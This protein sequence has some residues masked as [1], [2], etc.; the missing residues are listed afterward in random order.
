MDRLFDRRREND[1]ALSEEMELLRQKVSTLQEIIQRSEAELQEEKQKHLALQEKTALWKEKVKQSTMNDRRRIAELEEKLVLLKTVHV[2]ADAISE[3]GAQAAG[4]AVEQLSEGHIPSQQI[5]MHELQKAKETI[6]QR[7]AELRECQQSLNMLRD[8]HVEMQQRFSE[9]LEALTEHHRA[10][11]QK[12][13]EPSSDLERTAV[14]EQLVDEQK[15]KLQSLQDLTRQQNLQN[16]QLKGKIDDLQITNDALEKKWKSTMQAIE[17]MQNESRVAER[18]KGGEKENKSINKFNGNEE[19]VKTYK[20]EQSPF[21]SGV[22][23]EELRAANSALEERLAE[24]SRSLEA[25]RG[26][27]EQLRAVPTGR[28]WRPRRRSAACVPS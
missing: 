7:E 3:G 4:K 24:A 12:I 27:N 15:L 20:T 26:E 1:S 10:E 16:E 6:L 8:K 28:G 2:G 21:D 9:E 23:L 14:L 22:T 19:S 17:T 11:L 5:G 18:D 13:K 25:L